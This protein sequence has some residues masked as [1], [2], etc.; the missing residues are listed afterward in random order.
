MLS[1]VLA[2][3]GHMIKYSAV[4]RREVLAWASATEHTCSV[5]RSP[6]CGHAS[7]LPHMWFPCP[8][9]LSLLGLTRCQPPRLRAV[10]MRSEGRDQGDWKD[11]K[12]RGTEFC[13]HFMPQAGL[14]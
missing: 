8:R 9:C 5:L 4:G 14:S 10:E 2:L 11:G 6:H 7:G 13:Q 1:K 3:W 12:S